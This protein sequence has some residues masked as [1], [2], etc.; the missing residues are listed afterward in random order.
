KLGAGDRKPPGPTVRPLTSSGHRSITAAKLE[1]SLGSPSRA[2]IREP[3]FVAPEQLT[4]AESV[5]VD[6]AKHTLEWCVGAEGKIQHTR[7]EPRPI[8]QLVRQ[9]VAL[10]PESIVVESTG[11][12][13]RTLVTKLAEGR[14]PGRRREPEAGPQL[15]PGHGNPRQDRRHRRA[16]PRALGQEG[17][18]EVS[19]D[20]AGQ[21]ASPGRSRR[22]SPTARLDRRR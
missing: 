15:R 19:P 16:A 14:A 21:S 13:E 5:G 9:L 6:V 10:A 18:A 8:G 11:G 7:N 4:M 2:R 17:G 1:R 20:P 12:Y 22:A 3:E